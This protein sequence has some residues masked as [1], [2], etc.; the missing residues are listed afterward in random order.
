MERIAAL[1]DNPTALRK[2]SP[3]TVLLGGVG[4]IYFL[5]G[6]EYDE[7]ATARSIPQPL[8]LLQ[9]DRDYQV[10]VANDLHVWLQGLMGRKGVTV[11]QFPKADHLFLNGSGAPSPLEYQKPGHVDPK[12]IGT[13]A[14]W[15]DGV[16]T[17]PVN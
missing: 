17:A 8:L 15:I 11:V 6:L 10:T 12:V 2:E 16:K 1:I 4:P 9:G 13:I 14:S 3:G 7:V 5:S